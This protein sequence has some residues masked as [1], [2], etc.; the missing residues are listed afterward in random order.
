[1][2]SEIAPETLPHTHHDHAHHGHDHAY[3]KPSA[4]RAFPAALAPSLLRLGLLERLLIA[5]GL[6]ALIWLMILGVL[7]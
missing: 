5:G 2:K 4:G 7:A 3:A 1:M 6:V